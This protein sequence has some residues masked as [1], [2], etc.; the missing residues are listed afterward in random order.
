MNVAREIRVLLYR[1]RSVAAAVPLA[2]RHYGDFDWAYSA[3]FL[4]HKLR[5]LE[6]V[7]RA[8][9]LHEGSDVAAD[10]IA[11]LLDCLDAAQNAVARIPRPADLP[12][13]WADDAT[14]ESRARG[15]DWALAVNDL[16]HRSWE[17]ACEILRL[18]WREW[19]C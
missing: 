9:Q 19:W 7:M 2:W 4:T 14:D 6:R 5:R 17:R 13:P 1:L 15:H 18:H 8:D 3:A 11:E 12:M 16:E 10:Q